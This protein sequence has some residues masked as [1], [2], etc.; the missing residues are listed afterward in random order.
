M[1]SDKAKPKMAYENNC[2]L[3]EGFLAQPTIKEPNTEPIPA[4]EIIT[5]II[6]FIIIKK[7]I[8]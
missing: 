3:R 5:C 7:K 2:C 6:L 1:A 8:I 4:P